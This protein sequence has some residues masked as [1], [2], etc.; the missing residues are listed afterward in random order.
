[1][2]VNFGSGLED[3]KQSS[4]QLV[5]LYSP[6]ESL[7]GRQILAATNFPVRSIGIK[8]FF[9]TMGVVFDDTATEFPTVLV[10]VGRP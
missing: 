6:P 2:E 5:D 4:A 1:V 7:V 10:S 8:S 9:L 3:L